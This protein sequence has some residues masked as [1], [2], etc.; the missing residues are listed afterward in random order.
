[1]VVFLDKAKAIILENGNAQNLQPIIS[2][3]SQPDVIILQL[4]PY[5]KCTGKQQ[6]ASWYDS[7]CLHG[8]VTALP[9][10]LVKTCL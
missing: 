5:R 9:G 10:L 8:I 7:L 6:T 3:L 1:M 4:F 2:N